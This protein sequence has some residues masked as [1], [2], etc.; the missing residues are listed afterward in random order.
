MPNPT[1][2]ALAE[3]QDELMA[4]RRLAGR[5]TTELRAAVK[6]LA[7]E[8]RGASAMAER[9]KVE[10]TTC[11]RIISTIDA[12][13]LAPEQTLVDLPGPRALRQ[14][15]AALR[16]AGLADTS[17]DPLANAVDLFAEF[18][19]ETAGS[20]AGLARKLAGAA[21][22][23]LVDSVPQR[24]DVVQAA[25]MHKD[26]VTFCGSDADVDYSVRILRKLPEDPRLYDEIYCR[27]FSG[28]TA[29][30]K[31]RPLAI[32]S[33]VNARSNPD[34]SDV[35]HQTT[36]FDGQTAL[37]RTVNC[38]LP[39]FCSDPLPVVVG[40]GAGLN[41]GVVHVIDPTA[42]RDGRKVDVATL[43]RHVTLDFDPA[44]PILEDKEFWYLIN[45]PA[46]HIVV[47]IYVEKSIFQKP[48][49]PVAG[50]HTW[51]PGFETGNSPRWLSELPVWPT[52]SLLPAN[53][54]HA[55]HDVFPRM[56]EL[57]THMFEI[58]HADRSNFNGFRLD[59]AFPLWR[60]FYRV[61]FDFVS[62]T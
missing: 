9:L 54:Q 52:I 16:G 15:V 28:Y 10:K 40:G 60:T 39:R 42:F 33:T 5:L 8:F 3:D 20:Q 7:P 14:F 53:T 22:G 32:W 41:R 19:R 58:A 37:G 56:A 17:L 43:S 31:A 35:P 55:T 2:Q 51:D 34:G 47:D 12:R 26:A 21:T 6:L 57:T 1:S 23:N 36:S 30:S 29:T 59:V 44:D 45:Y 62:G 61:G 50:C 13:L 38:L 27:G 18:L 4:G 46:R 49:L 11:H 24:L 25:R 48:N